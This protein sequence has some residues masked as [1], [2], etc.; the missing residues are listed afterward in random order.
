[1]SLHK[2]LKSKDTLRRHRN[3]LTRPE[4]VEKLMELGHWDEGRSPLHL[5]KVAHRKVAV[6]KKEK[7]I[8]KADETATGKEGPKESKS[9]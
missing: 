7:G 2:S 3:V 9:D 1:M 4:R 5:P 6:G 8:K